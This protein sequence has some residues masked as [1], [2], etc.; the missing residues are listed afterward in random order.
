MRVK[1]LELQGYKTFA[2]K[3]EFLFGEGITAIVGPN[4]SGKSNIADAVRWVLGE[5]SYK[6]LRGK[7]TVDM[8]FSGSESR[9][10]MGM[11]QAALTLDNSDGWLPVEFSE[12]TIA[13]RAYRS[14]E[15]E[16]LLNGNRVRLRDITELLA[17]GGLSR[18][19][20]TVIGQGLVDT[21]LSL[22]PGERRTLFE[23]AAGITVHQAK[24]DGA[25][26]KLEDTQQNLLRVND[27]ISEIG[28][29]LERLKRQAER[30]QEYAQLSQELEGLLR[31]WY[32][33]RWRQGQKTLRQA[34]ARAREQRTRLEGRREEL[35][36]MEQRIA[37]VRTQQAE[38]RGQLSQWHRESSALHAEAE[39]LQR[40]L[41]VCQERK[42][43]LSQRR[44][45]I[46][47][48]VVPLEVNQ[49]AQRERIAQIEEELSRIE[50]Q[51][52][53]GT[54]Q[55]RDAQEQL[56]HHESQR[57]AL[58]KQ[59]AALRQQTLGLSTELADQKNRLTQLDERQ[60]ELRGEREGHQQAIAG[61]EAEKAMTEERLRTV[62]GQMDALQA[63][64]QTLA[65]QKE[66]KEREIEVEQEHQTQLQASLAEIQRQEERLLAR[67]ELLAGMREEMAGY[68]AGV[69]RV[70]QAAG[71][72]QLSG[73]VGTVVSLIEVPIEL[74][75]AIETT[76]GTH[77]QDI[78]VETWADAE[79]A[80]GFLKETGGGLATFLPLDTM[81]SPEPISPPKETGILGL[82][83]EL[84]GCKAQ[85]R[86]AL[87]VLLGRTV[88][89]EDLRMA[90]Q[91][92]GQMPRDSYPYQM[93]TLAGEVAHSN[94]IITGGATKDQGG[95]L[96]AHEREWRELPD[97][98]AMVRQKQQELEEH[99]QRAEEVHQ[100]LLAALV[101]LEGRESE[102]RTA[103]EARAA[104]A[105]VVERQIERLAQE[106]EWWQGLDKQ[107][108]EEM[109]ALDEKK[110]GIG[111]EVERLE[112][113]QTLVQEE[114][115]ALEGQL[116]VM[117][118]QDLYERLA[119][120]KTD[121]AVT[122]QSH[123]E[124]KTI[125]HSHQANLEH[126]E[127]Q[128][129]A[130]QERADELAQEGKALADQTRELQARE[131]ELSGQIQ[132]LAGLIEPTEAEL[133]ELENQQVELEGEESG[134]RTRLQRYETIYS[135]ATL[136]MERRRDELVSLRQ[137][138]QNDLG[139]VELELTDLMP[140]QPPLPIKPLVSTL[141][142]VDKLPEGLE[143]EVQRLKIQ[144][145]RAGS[146]NPNAPAEYAEALERHTFL[147]AQVEDLEQ[148]SDSLRQ[149]IAELDQLMEADFRKTFETVAVEFKEC[150]TT[151]FDGG[152]AKLVLTDPENLMETGVDIVARPPG[153]RQQ[154]LALLSGGERALTAA[155]LIFAIL[156]AS[157]TPF[158]ILDEVDAMLDE[159]NIGRFRKMLQELAD[160]TQFVVITHNRGTIEA[161]NT[162][163]GVS[164]GEDSVSKV[165]SLKLE[166]ESVTA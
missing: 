80:I 45:E 131:E 77:G 28:P 82:A 105:D 49:E 92:M 152:T 94:G 8:I 89:V 96:L 34:R 27:I 148:A 90:H 135:Q 109:A 21:A 132:A 116:E 95:G 78:V 22:R 5:Q 134:C 62:K 42:R 38:K 141:P 165:I 107:L 137:Q 43:L 159:V 51:L 73:I 10:R 142:P 150:F 67:Q 158:C 124:R 76:L 100:Q 157:P 53:E 123:K 58:V 41:A 13:R 104:E 143:D 24:R 72:G 56:D 163:Y 108:D 44:E 55:V 126:V 145:K 61:Q 99:V 30:A 29:R 35:A 156:K 65:A 98:L 75:T 20:Y 103:S 59:L 26:A 74:E 88:V 39:K 32:G 140:G 19:T 57:Q 130:K 147:T 121:L 40:E 118:G 36:E 117:T 106:I 162:I 122:E 136:D 102:L 112:A 48:E 144:L 138:I 17:K 119:Q 120:F 37:Q 101:D 11:A 83:V 1:D 46:L 110:V 86:P 14:G 16:Y 113:G 47:Q 154:S 7:S 66:D 9:P 3:T 33:Y 97:R 149:V 114:I 52:E 69:R 79:A 146:I 93:V 63:Q 2:A 71:A 91:I 12:V 133:V 85:L 139:L 151:L 128:I 23:E 155:A 25:I 129:A 4:G 166:G 160:R 68:Q 111:Q 18:R 127:G 64:V 70:M 54:A 161:A 15:N 115:A 125:L 31:L 164:M 87:D 84:I 60:E 153:K 81:R 50:S 6:M